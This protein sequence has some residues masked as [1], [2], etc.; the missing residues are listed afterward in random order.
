MSEI[1]KKKLDN[2]IKAKDSFLEELITR[3][4]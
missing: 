4:V 1:S 2:L 3:Q